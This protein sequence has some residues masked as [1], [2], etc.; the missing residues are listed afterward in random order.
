[1]FTD[2]LLEPDSV[3]EMLGRCE[4]DEVESNAGDNRDMAPVTGRLF[5]ESTLRFVRCQ[6]YVDIAYCDVEPGI[7]P[8]SSSGRRVECSEYFGKGCSEI[9]TVGAEYSAN[10]QDVPILLPSLIAFYSASVAH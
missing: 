2:G 7:S 8:V 10:K 4:N 9:P 1:M 6:D 5:R 3:D